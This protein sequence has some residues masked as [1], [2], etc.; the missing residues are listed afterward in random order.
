MRRLT[1]MALLWLV[2]LGTARADGPWRPSGTMSALLPID[3]EDGGVGGGL[4]LDLWQPVG[5]F[6]FGFAAGL[7][8]LSSH[9]PS[10]SA[11]VTPLAASVG[12]GTTP[13]PVGLRAYV[14]AGVWGGAT[15]SGL[16][17]GALLCGGVALDVRLDE[18]LALGIAAEAWRSWGSWDRLTIA[19]SL[20]LVW[21]L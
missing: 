12:I 17:G 20:S 7:M 18:V 13:R 3:V 2:A 8:A 6:H 4:L 9:D 19:P 16:R 11:I 21:R 1:L 15:N 5:A 14:R 10:A